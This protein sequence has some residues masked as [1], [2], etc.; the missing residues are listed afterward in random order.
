MKLTKNREIILDYLGVLCVITRTFENGR[1]EQKRSQLE[2]EGWQRKQ[3]S[4]FDMGRTRPARAG[5]GDAGKEPP[6]KKDRWLPDAEEGKE[7][8]LVLILVS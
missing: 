6:A 3:C 7:T 4:W 2:Q 1:G 8:D 5:F